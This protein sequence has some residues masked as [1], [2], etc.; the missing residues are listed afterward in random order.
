MKF[1]R[2]GIMHETHLQ[3][4]IEKYLLTYRG[5]VERSGEFI[6]YDIPPGY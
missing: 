6:L 2:G 3:L 5:L 1:M 4:R